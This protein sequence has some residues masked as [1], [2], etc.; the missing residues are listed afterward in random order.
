MPDAGDLFLVAQTLL[1]ACE[2]I[3]AADSPGGPVAFS[4]VWQGLPSFDCE[5]DSL[6]VDL[7][8]PAVGNTYPLQPPL[9]ELQR[10]VTTGQ[11]NII[12][13]HITVL[14]CISVLEN[15]GQTLMLPSAAQITEDSRI[16]YGDLW[17][18]WNGLKNR[19]RLGTLFQT[20][21]GRRE[22]GFDPAAAVRTSGGV[23]GWL[24]Q[25]RVEVPGYS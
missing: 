19:H 16:C 23:G 13:F 14:R 1:T 5:Q 15:D 2:Q 3:L 22:F 8:G 18:L 4:A 12:T 20:L 6:Y 25:I 11:V 10:I 7:G 24:I 21:S 9:E 17:A